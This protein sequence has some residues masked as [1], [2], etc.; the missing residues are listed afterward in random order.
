MD[1]KVV[2]KVA[3]VQADLLQTKNALL[4]FIANGARF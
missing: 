1:E 2:T 3:F 4:V